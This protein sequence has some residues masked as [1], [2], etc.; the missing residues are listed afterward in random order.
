M[1]EKVILARLA[2]HHSQQSSA[3]W[4]PLGLAIVPPI[5]GQAM[6]LAFRAT[7][8]RVNF[9]EIQLR[10]PIV[11]VTGFGTIGKA[12]DDTRI[13]LG[14]FFSFLLFGASLLFFRIEQQVGVG[15]IFSRHLFL[16]HSRGKDKVSAIRGPCRFAD[17]V[18][19]LGQRARL[20]AICGNQIDLGLC[21]VTA[22]GR[23]K[24]HPATIRRP[25]RGAI[26]PCTAGELAGTSAPTRRE[27]DG[28]LVPVGLQV[29]LGA[30]VGEPLPIRT[31]IGI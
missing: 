31:E 24:G 19:H 11:K 12:A 16:T 23:N 10:R 29:W 14:L 15:F 7:C 9:L 4:H 20:A 8:L 6:G 28:A 26:T 2:A 22:A 1:V 30:D 21:L 17:S 13:G 25:A 3:I 18:F 27:P 5:V